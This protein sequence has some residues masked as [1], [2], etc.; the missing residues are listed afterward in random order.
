MMDLAKRLAALLPHEARG[1][2]PNWEANYRI[3]LLWYCGVD[4]RDFV[5]E[6]ATRRQ[7]PGAAAGAVA[8][9]PRCTGRSST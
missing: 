7:D 6:L 2:V 8:P 5:G 9:P 4:A 3:P 1:P